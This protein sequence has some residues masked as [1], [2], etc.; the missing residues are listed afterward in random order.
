MSKDFNQKVFEES[1]AFEIPGE[2]LDTLFE[3]LPPEG[4][5][6]ASNPSSMGMRRIITGLVLS[7]I[8]FEFFALNHILPAIGAILLLM[9]FRNLHREN[10]WF[11][12]S[13]I[14][15]VLRFIVML[16]G[17]F[18][19]AT[20]YSKL[21]GGIW[22]RYIVILSCILTVFMLFC[23]WMATDQVQDKAGSEEKSFSAGAL[24]LWYVLLLA[25]SLIGFTGILTSILMI[26]A[27]IMII[28]SLSS[29]SQ[30]METKGY[31]ITAAS[32]RISDRWLGYILGGILISG[33][34]FG[35]IFASSYQMKWIPV[36][37]T[38]DE[39]DAAYLHLAELGYPKEQLN[40]L[41]EDEIT[42]LRDADCVVVKKDEKNLS[43]M[44]AYDSYEDGKLLNH[45]EP[46][47]ELRL[48]HVAVRIAGDGSEGE[49][50]RVIHHF[51]IDD[52][53]R[54]KGTC[55]IKLWTLETMDGWDGTKDMSGRLLC[56]KQ[57]VDMTADYV[58]A[59]QVSYETNDFFGQSREDA[60]CMFDFS[61]PK[62]ASDR[63]GYVAYTSKQV[64]DGWILS[65]WVNFTSQIG[66][67]QYPVKT[68]RQ[69]T[70]EGIHLNDYPFSDIQ[71]A[72][73]FYVKDGTPDEES[74]SEFGMD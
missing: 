64:E 55:N 42:L 17:L 59:E 18:L 2:L 21:L 52:V 16:P 7:C 12:T 49:F 27:F 11:F 45:Y 58:L 29:L 65:S 25:C 39:S 24:F 46:P 8:T 26:L 37:D 41:T 22:G 48:I 74:L 38:V 57:G 34:F 71:S 20:I 35:F 30:L 73:Q 3:E 61:L 60:S 9:G 63:R 70:M 68:A 72:I 36:T 53:V 33:L 50:W 56:K 14:C 19:N 62:K 23:F 54:M 67:L 32:V 28:K 1:D 66:Y 4:V 31:L 10:T 40:D 47:T 5:V 44:E 69:F 43:G 15:S 6:N 51:A 13:Y